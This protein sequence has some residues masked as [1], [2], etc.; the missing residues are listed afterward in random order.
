LPALTLSIQGQARFVDLPARSTLVRWIRAAIERDSQLTLRFVDAREGRRLNRDYRSKDYATDVLTFGY[1]AEPV[2]H[3]D[4]V[5]CVPVV[6]REASA[7][8]KPI[9]DHLAHLI[10]HATL[11]AHGYHH[12]NVAAAQAVEA[13]ERGILKALGK[14]APY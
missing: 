13:R 7:R 11:H 2:V 8:R 14:R 5:I 12:D 4:I 9:Y 3:A 1:A 10:V 6:K